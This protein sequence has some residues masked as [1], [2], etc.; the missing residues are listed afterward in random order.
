M[1]FLHQRYL[2]LASHHPEHCVSANCR[3][4]WLQLAATTAYDPHARRR[5]RDG[6]RVEDCA[7]YERNCET[8]DDPPRGAFVVLV[9]EPMQSL[10]LPL[11]LW[12][13]DQRHEAKHLDNVR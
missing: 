1:R 7:N 4:C 2:Q 3:R 5:R 10:Q 12:Q 13:K 9:A 11:L 8:P 6:Q